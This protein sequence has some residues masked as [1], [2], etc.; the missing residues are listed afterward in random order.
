MNK[1]SWVIGIDFG[2]DSVRTIVVNALS[3]EEAASSLFEYPRWKAGLFS[4]PAVNQFRQHPLDYL[5]GLEH[6]ILECVGQLSK[7]QRENIR[8][9][10][11]DTP[12]Q[13]L[14]R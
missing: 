3:G 9:I 13:H 4:D 5:E 11:V 12:V 6:G 7:E 10:G 2:T 8:G 14:L 1:Q